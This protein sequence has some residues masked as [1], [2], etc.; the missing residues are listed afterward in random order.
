M[1]CL[2]K[3]HSVLNRIKCGAPFDTAIAPFSS[4]LVGDRVL[5]CKHWDSI[6]DAVQAAAL[7]RPAIERAKGKISVTAGIIYREYPVPEAQRK[8]AKKIWRCGGA[9]DNICLV[10][11]LQP[12]SR[13]YL[14]EKFEQVKEP[15]FIK[16]DDDKAERVIWVSKEVYAG[17]EEELRRCRG[18][19]LFKDYLIDKSGKKTR[20]IC[21]SD[22][23]YEKSTDRRVLTHEQLETH[24]PNCQ[25]LSV[26]RVGDAVAAGDERAAGDLIM[27]AVSDNHTGNHRPHRHTVLIPPYAST[28]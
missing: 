25:T 8:V 27:Q 24:F 21:K 17:Y 4:W 1:A 15:T 22:G 19:R 10:L 26:S 16:A 23:F 13:V 11:V 18:P 3:A 28:R 7:L 5:I 12:T 2:K 20:V 9:V 6:E 14:T